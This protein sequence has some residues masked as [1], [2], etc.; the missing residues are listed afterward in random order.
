MT[1]SFLKKRGLLVS[2]AAGLGMALCLTALLCLALAALIQRQTLPMSAAG[3]GAALAAGL[4]VFAAV[5]LI[6]GRRQR[7]A[8]PLAGLVAGGFLLLA[9]LLCALDSGGADFGPWLLRLGGTVSAG[10]I[11]G[12]IMSIGQNTHTKRRRPRR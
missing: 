12:A 3:L 6:A 8:M 10:G 2:A 4:S 11:L 9:A 5:L 1:C 7:Q